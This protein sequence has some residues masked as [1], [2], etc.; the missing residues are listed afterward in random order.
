MAKNQ[1]KILMIQPC[2]FGFGGH[3]RSGHLA[4]N[5]RKKNLI[6]DHIFSSKN[7]VYWEIKTPN[8]IDIALP[9]FS[10]GH[11]ITG[12]LFRSFKIILFILKNQNKYHKIHFF[13]IC[14]LECLLPS[15][16]LYFLI[17]KKVIIDWDDYWSAADEVT[18]KYS[19]NGVLFYLRFVEKYSAKIFKNFTVASDF[20][21]NKIGKSKSHCIIINSVD[22]H[23]CHVLQDST[24]TYPTIL[25][26]G[27][28]MFA[29]RSKYLHRFSKK[30][31]TFH[32]KAEIISNVSLSDFKAQL[33]AADLNDDFGYYKEIG[34]INSTLL[35]ILSSRISAS[36][37]FM[38]NSMSE[39]ACSPTRIMTLRKLGVPLITVENE[40]YT[41][42]NLK[43]IKCVIS[44]SS[45]ESV[46]VEFWNLFSSDNWS[47]FRKTASQNWD[48]YPSWEQTSEKLLKFYR[49]M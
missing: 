29:E 2:H 16:I 41:F 25:S 34:Y 33:D 6:V 23:K 8:G 30:L 44:G 36:A 20:L 35:E 14:Q 12:R 13:N 48:Y 49:E 5:L 45:P 15:I 21:A 22:H 7:H 37:F 27:N 28:T 18:Q 10:I 46:A 17:N 43:K 42:K 39:R 38:S 31:L 11:F 32:P 40:T 3:I 24:Q 26:I 19:N 9:R 1:I 4:V 47:N